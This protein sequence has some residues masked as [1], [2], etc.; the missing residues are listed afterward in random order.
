MPCQP[1]F[2]KS[3]HKTLT[4]SAPLPRAETASV[5][6]PLW[7]C[8]CVPSA[9]CLLPT[10]CTHLDPKSEPRTP[11]RRWY[12]F[13][14]AA[15]KGERRPH[16]PPHPKRTRKPYSPRFLTT[17]HTH[18]HTHTH[19]HRAKGGGPGGPAHVCLLHLPP[20]LCFC[21]F[22]LVLSD[23]PSR[24]LEGVR[25]P[26]ESLGH[27]LTSPVRKTCKCTPCISSHLPLA[28]QTSVVRFGSRE[29]PLCLPSPVL[30]PSSSQAGPEAVL[31]L[32]SSPGSWGSGDRGQTVPVGAGEGRGPQAKCWLVCQGPRAG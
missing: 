31:G 8:P 10:V 2:P 17:V 20:P 12:G 21:G 5:L 13:S 30:P 28:S 9:P 4:A 24:S 22:A 32:D 26:P 6:V 25:S 29:H 27:P 11:P 14:P 7:M 3:K 19:T 15:S 1:Q 18:T 16:G 23:P